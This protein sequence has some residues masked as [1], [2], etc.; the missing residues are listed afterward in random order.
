MDTQPAQPH[1]ETE[2][3]GGLCS[4]RWLGTN[5]LVIRSGASCLMVDPH[6]SRPP[7]PAL[8]FK[9]APRIRA[10]EQGLNGL[11]LPRLDA[12]LITHT[13]YDH[14]L[15][16]FET[17]RL[18]GADLYGSESAVRAGSGQ[19]RQPFRMIEVQP[20][21]QYAIGDIRARFFVSS[22][23]KSPGGLAERTHFDGMIEKPLNPPQWFWYYRAGTVYNIL[24]E[25]HGHRL[26]IQ[27]S[28]GVNDG[29][30]GAAQADAAVISIAGLGFRNRQ[31]QNRW[32]EQTILQS[33]A[34]EVWFSHWDNFFVPW[35]PK[36][37]DLPGIRRA[38]RRI[39][40]MSAAC[41]GVTFSRLKPG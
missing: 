21:V 34:R 11:H 10:I 28:A 17:A 32:F 14:F 22:H 30:A 39:G 2:L 1:S 29:I 3:F 38:I 19:H 24:L 23:L 40:A 37:H 31:Y 6:F 33:G 20:G 18:T 5:C 41:P 36:P 8:G 16:A 35:G 13:H 4:I 15:D 9:I 7:L 26:L 25:M 12:V 27:G